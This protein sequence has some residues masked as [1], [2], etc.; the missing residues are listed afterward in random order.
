MIF[1][2]EGATDTTA[3]VF[4]DTQMTSIRGSL[5]S[6]IEGVKDAFIDL[7][8]II[9]LVTAAVFG[10]NFVKGKFNKVG[11]IRG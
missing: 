2:A 6:T 7:L 9:V 5:T 3:K 4:T 11:R 8:P 10:I 1:F